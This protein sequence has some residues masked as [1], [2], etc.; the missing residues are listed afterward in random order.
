M[1]E[2]FAF[3]NVRGTDI[4]PPEATEQFDGMEWTKIAKD[5]DEWD[6]SLRDIYVLET[7]AADWDSMLARLCSFEPLPTFTVNG[8]A[9]EWPKQVARV[10]GIRDK[11]NPMLTVMVGAATLNCHFFCV[12]E[13]EFDL[14]P[15]EITGPPQAEALASF[16]R[17][18]SEATQK[19]VILCHENAQHAVI[20][21]YSPTDG[22]A[23]WVGTKEQ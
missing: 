14:D 4:A 17:L 3:C 10:F 19:T 16:M 8:V 1:S 22:E 13:I 6:G 21:Q 5:F 15:R 20:A 7:T 18:L 2:S 12:N 23:T 11:N 9:Q